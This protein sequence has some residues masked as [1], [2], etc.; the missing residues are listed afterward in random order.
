MCLV[1]RLSP[2]SVDDE[3]LVEINHLKLLQ[4]LYL[5]YCHPEHKRALNS[6]V[7]P[8]RSGL[9]SLAMLVLR[10]LAELALSAAN[11]SG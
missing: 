2:P 1:L 11:G 6:L 7:V 3:V 9:R 10:S 5:R 4:Q 8:T